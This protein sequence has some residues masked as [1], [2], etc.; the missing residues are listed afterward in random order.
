MAITRTTSEQIAA[1]GG[2]VDRVRLDAT[3]EEDIRRHMI[4]DGE[5][6]DEDPRFEPPVQAQAVRAASR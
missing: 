5:D 4:E 2:R 6:P 1:A 3:T